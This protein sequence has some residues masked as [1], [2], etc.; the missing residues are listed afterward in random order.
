VQ[1]QVRLDLQAST[2]AFPVLGFEREFAGIRYWKMPDDVRRYKRVIEQSRP[3]VVIETGTRWGGFALMLR[4][5]GVH[6]VTIDVDSSFSEEA[7]SRG[8]AGISWLF[9][10]STSGGVVNQAA[11]I[12]RG[13]RTMVSLDSEHSAPHVAREISAYGP[14]VTPG[15]YLVVEDGVFDLMGEHGSIGG[16]RIPQQGGPLR[17][18]ASC[19]AGSPEW[20]RDTETEWLTPV[21]HS[22]AG[23]WRRA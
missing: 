2:A 23:W 15:C 12:A 7:R 4:S 16:D 21:T 13:K 22:P 20:V 11:E 18:I 17:A 1:V 5:W 3:E 6:V 14:L 9:G 10:D 8:D 19:L